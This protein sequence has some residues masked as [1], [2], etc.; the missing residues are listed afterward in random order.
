MKQVCMTP[1]M[2]K[3]LIGKGMAV[4][5]AIQAVLK[6]GTLVIIG[7]TTNGYVAEEV[8]NSIG[9]A[10]GF[11]RFGFR[12]GV[13]AA[14]GVKA[15]KTDFPGDVVIRDGERLPGRTIQDTVDELVEG[16]V[17]LKG[18][19]AFDARGQAAVQIGS[20]VGGT[21]WLAVSAVI[22]RRVQLIVPI[23]LEK[24]VLE[25]VNVL[26]MRCNAPGG[27]GPGF[28]PLPAPIFTELDAIKL[29]TGADASLLAGGGVYG[30]EGASWLI[31]DGSDEQVDA[32][33]E[34]IDSLVGRAALR[35]VGASRRSSGL[36]PV[37][38]GPNNATPGD[39]AYQESDMFPA[40]TVRTSQTADLSVQG[41]LLD[42]DKFASHDGPGIR[43]TVFLKGCPLSCIWCHSPESRHVDAELIYQ[44][45]R[46]TGCWLCLEA[47]PTHALSIGSNGNGEAAVLDRT[48]CDVC[49]LCAEVCYPGA[50]KMAGSRVTVG[51]LAAQVQKDIAYFR[52]SGGGVTLSGGEPARQA[53]FSYHFLLACREAGI[54]TAL[55][56]TGY[57]RWEVIAALASVTDLFLYDIKFADSDAHRRYTG[58]P[59]RVILDNLQR[60]AEMGSEIHVRVPCIAGVNDSPEQIQAVSRLVS[61][62][63]LSRIVLLP[64]N[65][66]AGAK[67]EWLGWEFAL[68]HAATQSEE[69]MNELADICRRDGL[70]VQ[71]GG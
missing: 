21:A 12:R 31:L 34:L 49:G 64:Y 59:N 42:I 53:Q 14:P 58:V 35:G 26:A 18:G 71:I 60:L 69:T 36:R 52:T 45:D 17:I 51:E 65:G 19:N 67:Y 28:F 39:V 6:Q 27:E 54:H 25:D 70:H 7:G 38:A 68:P 16:D 46:C 50:L 43:T 5:P 32:A 44:A 23:G 22:G 24:R 63:G 30:A 57:A 9:Q 48:R 47:C 10:Q 13:T 3:R 62:M 55:E 66:A 15:P 20:N 56:T 40:S 37:S 1:A 41:L 4:H 11:S 8:L 29:L 61:G 33:V 2:G